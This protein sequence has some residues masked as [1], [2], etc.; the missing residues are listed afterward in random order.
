ML[1]A[2]GGRLGG[3]DDKGDDGAVAGL[4]A[5]LG[6]SDAGLCV[7]RATSSASLVVKRLLSFWL[8]IA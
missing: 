1:A 2:L 6:D 4:E 3:G 8:R 5:Q 7:G